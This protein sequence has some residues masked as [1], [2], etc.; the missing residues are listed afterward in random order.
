MRYACDTEKYDPYTLG[1]LQFIAELDSIPDYM[2]Y[3][4]NDLSGIDK[5][6]IYYPVA[7]YDSDNCLICKYRNK[8]LYHS[9]E[10]SGSG[11]PPTPE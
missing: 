6:K 11:S 10:P 1:P 2:S 4:Y 9:M 8:V 7:E 3:L 5:G